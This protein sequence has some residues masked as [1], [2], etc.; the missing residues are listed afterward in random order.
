MALPRKNRLVGKKNFDK[1]FKEGK[2][3]RGS[4][5]FIK[6]ILNNQ[7]ASRFGLIISSKIFKKATER[8]RVKRIIYELIRLR[9]DKIKSGYD[10]VIIF[11]IKT[12]ERSLKEDLERLLRVC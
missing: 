11:K 12:D 4:F 3:V 1:V 9:I 10:L 7:S 5:L 2:T 8:N 6:K